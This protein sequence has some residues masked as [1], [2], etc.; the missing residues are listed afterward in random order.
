[1][2]LRKEWVREREGGE[3]RKG[4]KEGVGWMGT[5]EKVEITAKTQKSCQ[6]QLSISEAQMHCLLSLSYES[7]E[8]PQRML[9]RTSPEHSR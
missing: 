6:K 9:R 5:Q 4:R 1:M 3:R 2:F 7:A 8:I